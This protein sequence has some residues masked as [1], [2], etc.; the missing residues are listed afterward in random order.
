MNMKKKIFLL[1]I[2]TILLSGCS[3]NYNLNISEKQTIIENATV[4]VP[5]LDISGAFVEAENP[6]E[7]EKNYFDRE[8][9]NIASKYSITGYNQ[10]N[11][12]TNYVVKKETTYM[13]IESLKESKL[14]NELYNNITISNNGNIYTLNFSN[15]NDK[16]MEDGLQ[17]IEI[18]IKLPFYVESHNGKKDEDTYTWNLSF[19]NRNDI[20]LKFDISRKYN[21]EIKNNEEETNNKINSKI[22]IYVVLGIITT[23]IIL[24]LI[25]KKKFNKNNEI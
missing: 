14:L 20:K 5:K 22:I 10:N 21:E 4:T 9:K 1:I 23:I 24:F 8:L 3:A 15:F 25:L 12:S 18:K 19:K 17:N 13:T 16:I 7:A 11:T 6:D 2:I